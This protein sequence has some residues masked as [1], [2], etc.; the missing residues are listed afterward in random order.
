MI[1]LE[2]DPYIEK[3]PSK[4]RNGKLI[5]DYLVVASLNDNDDDDIHIHTSFHIQ[6]QQQQQRSIG[7]QLK[8]I[9]YIRKKNNNWNWEK[10][11]TKPNKTGSQ[12]RWNEWERKKWLLS[13]NETI[14]AKY[15]WVKSMRFSQ[16]KW[17]GQFLYNNNTHIVELH[18]QFVMMMMK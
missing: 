12:I 17:N 9:Y 13:Q 6:L 10:T 15:I 2:K 5:N 3:K 8:I 18:N 4:R 7:Q 1:D 14:A 16:M 11:K